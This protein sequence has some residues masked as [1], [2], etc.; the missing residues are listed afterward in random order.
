ML[1][2][3]FKGIT[4]LKSVCNCSMTITGGTEGGHTTHGPNLPPIDLAF[5]GN[6]DKYILDN[7]VLSI[8][9]RVIPGVGTLYTSMV[10]GRQVSFLKESD[11]WHV[12]F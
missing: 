5:N 8:P 1:P 7:R 10:N 3:T 11:H 4:D 9:P 12:V 6:L 2:S